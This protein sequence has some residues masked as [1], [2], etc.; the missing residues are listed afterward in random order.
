[1]NRLAKSIFLAILLLIT[2][3]VHSQN[4]ISFLKDIE[5][6]KT[7]RIDSLLAFNKEKNKLEYLAV[8]PSINYNFFENSFNVGISLSNLAGFYQTKHR[9]KIEL[10]RLKLQLIDKKD[11][12][13]LEL[14]KEYELIRDT[15][16]ILKMELDN[17]TLATEIFNLKKA[18]YDNNKITLEDWLNV[19]KNQQDRNLLLFAKRK[20]LISKMKQFETKIKKNCFSAELKYLAND[21]I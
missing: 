15:Y 14:E 16:E 2:T 20:N 7:N 18:Q 1:M 9:N 5:K 4:S 3:S 17:T 19:Q 6:E 12:E 21:V 11:N 8:L 10:E 13:L